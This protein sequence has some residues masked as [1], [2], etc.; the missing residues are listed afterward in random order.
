MVVS[1]DDSVYHILAPFHLPS[2]TFCKLQH[3]QARSRFRS[4][5]QS[6]SQSQTLCTSTK[7][8]RDADT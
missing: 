7:V 4:Q 3:S 6:Q 1:L 8:G 2:F 5:A